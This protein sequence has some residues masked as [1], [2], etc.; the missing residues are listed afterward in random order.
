M[1]IFLRRVPGGGGRAAQS[2]RADFSGSSRYQSGC[3]LEFLEAPAELCAN[4]LD[5][6]KGTITSTKRTVNP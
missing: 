6:G 1:E 4:R 2:G 5:G 3:L